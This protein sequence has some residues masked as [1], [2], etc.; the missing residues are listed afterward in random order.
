VRIVDVPKAGHSIWGDNPTFTANALVDMLAS[1]KPNTPNTPEHTAAYTPGQMMMIHTSSLKFAARVW[2]APDAPVLL[3]LHGTSMQSSAWTA[4]G[5]AL[6]RQWR[7]IALDMRGH[8]RSDK[9]ASGYAL[10]DYAHDVKIVLDALG[11]AKT[12]LIGSSLGT[13]V[14]I[15]FAAHHPDRVNQLILSDPSCLI[16]QSAIDHYVAL[17]RSRPRT[18][19]NWEAAMAFSKTLPQR[20]RF[21][22]AVHDHT[23]QGDLQVTS[24]GALEWCYALDPILQTFRAL[25]VDQTASIIAVQAPVL[26]LRGQHSH[27]L[28]RDNAL[29][30]RKRFARAELIEISDSSHTI[31]GDQPQALAREV[32]HFLLH[33]SV[34]NTELQYH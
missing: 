2:G 33:H 11:V 20:Q 32:E 34:Q 1:V 31:W 12:S 4:L 23:L 22:D 16:D 14:A 19:A 3:C 30:L 6:H 25:T 26:I 28:T 27:V 29:Q 8:G 9:P 7:V 10:S 24:S 5:S 18:F 21:S 17:H 13:Q 15:E